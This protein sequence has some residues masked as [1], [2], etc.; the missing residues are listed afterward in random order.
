[1]HVAVTAMAAAVGALQDAGEGR[2]GGGR[3]I[4]F[5]GSRA[6]REERKDEEGAQAEADEIWQ[7]GGRPPRALVRLL[8]EPTREN[9]E[10]YLA[11]QRER[12][13]K[14]QAAQERIRETVM[15]E[16]A[17]RVVGRGVEVEY[18]G[19]DGCPH[20]KTQEEILHRLEKRVAGISIRRVGPEDPEFRTVEVVPV[21][22]VK[23]G[24]RRARF[25]GVTSEM[26]ILR[27]MAR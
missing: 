1:M 7:E 3:W 13:K 19:K 9:A 26:T 25:D 6:E 23:V 24:R 20:C 21:V 27:E 2:F 4:D 22:V 18:I 15:S 17:E 10:K 14:I 16:M 12:M 11:W 5:W 8:E